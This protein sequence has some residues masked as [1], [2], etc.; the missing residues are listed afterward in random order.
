MNVSPRAPPPCSSLRGERRFRVYKGQQAPAQA[1]APRC[2]LTP[3]AAPRPPHPARPAPRSPLPPHSSGAYPSFS[4]SSSVCTPS[5]PALRRSAHFFRT[6]FTCALVAVFNSAS[7]ASSSSSS[8]GL[9]LVHCSAQREHSLG[10]LLLSFSDK[11][12]SG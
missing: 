12:G 6:A 8:E 2:P 1:P 10:E 7:S 11:H 3:P 9:T 5:S 4:S